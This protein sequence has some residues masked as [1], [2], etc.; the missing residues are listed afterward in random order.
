[1]NT[2]K[3][4][5]AVKSFLKY[6]IAERGYSRLTA[7]EYKQDLN[8]FAKYLE[9]EYDYELSEL[10]ID[11]I[12][13]FQISEFLSDIILIQDNAAATRNRKLYSMRSFFKFL[14]KRKIVEKNLALS[15]EATKTDLKAEPIYIEDNEINNY[16]NAIKEHNS[17]NCK[18]DLAINKSFI[19]CGLR[20][21]E[22]V[23]LDLDD[24][25]YKDQSIKFY[26]KG[27]KERYVPLHTEVINAIQAYLPD[28]N[29][30]NPKN[31]DAQSA[32]FL[33]NRGNRISVRTVQKMVKKYAKKS[34]VKN[35]A[36]I[37]PHKLRH[38]F[39]SLLYKKTKDLRVLQ[40]LLGHSDIST[41]QIYTHTDKK[42]RKDAVNQLPDF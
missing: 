39:A 33:S 29:K 17:K 1:M 12:N 38:T 22:L 7:K 27:S 42:Q 25:N 18:R 20:I 34:G 19:Y 26:G 3:Y 28:R 23:N 5:R 8:L 31:K 13:E 40:E 11:Q 4:R 36:K 37:T 24:I 15:I 35:A 30:I 32:L 10:M 2:I 21:S 14:I 9:K 6:L 41:T 16:F